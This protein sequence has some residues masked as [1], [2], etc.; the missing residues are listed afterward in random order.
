MSGFTL[1]ILFRGKLSRM[2]E[3]FTGLGL[4]VTIFTT[5]WTIDLI[6]TTETFEMI[7]SFQFWLIVM[8][9]IIG[10]WGMQIFGGNRIRRVAVLA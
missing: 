6:V 5:G 4:S 7:S 9:D 1:G 8:V 10:A 3:F 2:I